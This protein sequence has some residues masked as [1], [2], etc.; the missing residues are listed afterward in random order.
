[1]KSASRE[2][3]VQLRAVPVRRLF[4]TLRLQLS[5][6]RFHRRR[7]VTLRV[8]GE[9]LGAV[10]AVLEQPSTATDAAMR[11][12]RLKNGEGMIALHFDNGHAA[13]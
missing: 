7:N 2:F 13:L 4:V 9:A 12:S 6:R 8:E 3:H 11:F 5:M 1:M 10:G